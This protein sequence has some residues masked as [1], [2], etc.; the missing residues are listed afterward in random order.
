MLS[1]SRDNNTNLE[2]I[3]GV[4][5]ITALQES[6]L[7]RSFTSATINSKWS[8]LYGRIDLRAALPKGNLLKTAI[9]LLPEKNDYGRDRVNGEIEIV[10]D[11]QRESYYSRASYHGAFGAMKTYPSLD[12]FQEYSLEWNET[13]ITW[14]LNGS[15]RR[16]FDLDRIIDPSYYDRKGQPFD[17]KFYLAMRLQVFKFET[18][19]LLIDE[20][21][22]ET[23]KCPSLL[24]DYVRLYQQD[25]SDSKFSEEVASSD[26]APRK[27]K[28]DICNKVNKNLAQFYYRAFSTWKLV[29]IIVI[30]VSVLIIILVLGIYFYSKYKRN[31]QG[32]EEYADYMDVNNEERKTG[33]Y[34]YSDVVYAQTG[35]SYVIEQD[36]PGASNLDNEPQYLEMKPGSYAQ[37]KK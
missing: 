4:L 2:L 33:N 21:Y 17:K 12:E 27:T 1:Y 34:E 16:I 13:Q 3:D 28:E 23:W 35:N 18:D 15:V 14:S 19:E 37:L 32:Q 29:L 7:G 11:V 10:A 5:A 6:Y 8:F 20:K 9:L 30:P 24:I 31:D 26:K 22:H 36:R 25:N